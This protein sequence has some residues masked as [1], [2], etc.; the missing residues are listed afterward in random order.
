MTDQQPTPEEPGG[1]QRPPAPESH[2]DQPAQMQV[3]PDSPGT[4]SAGRRRP[5]AGTLAVAAAASGFAFGAVVFGMV[6]DD[7]DS[8]DSGGDDDRLRLIDR[9]GDEYGE[10]E[11]DEREYEEREY[12]EREYGEEGEEHEYYEDDDES[13]DEDEYGEREWDS[14]E[15]ARPGEGFGFS[16]P[17]T[18]TRGS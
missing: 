7:G 12:E 17:R 14:D 2:V 5:G 18:S 15:G 3:P 16:E 1:A 13:E 10:Y 11:Y 4:K 8:G 6:R 9:I